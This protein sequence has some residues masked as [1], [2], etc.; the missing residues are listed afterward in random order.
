MLNLAACILWNIWKSRND[1][2]F[3]NIHVSTSQCIQRALQDFKLFDL[4]QAYNYCSNIQ[5]NHSNAVLREFPPA[6]VI[7]INVDAAFNNGNAS[8]AAVAID[9]F[10]N[11][12]GSGSYCFN[13]ISSTVAEAKAYGL[14]IQ[15]A[16]RLQVT[17]II[18]EGDATEIPKAIQGSV[19]GIPWNIRSTILNIRDRV[20][21]FSEV[22]FTAVSRDANSIAHDL[23]QCAI[24]NN[25]NR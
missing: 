12:P 25:V 10:G 16:G 18:V 20:K 23:A 24:S 2:I 5:I 11:H 22:S 15:L 6:S 4:H 19:N 1:L 8:A 3:N 14:G 13:C 7:K 17:K 21:N 9:S